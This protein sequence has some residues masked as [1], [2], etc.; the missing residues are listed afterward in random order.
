M[1]FEKTYI[2]GKKICLIHID[3]VRLQL[4]YIEYKNERVRVLYYK[5]KRLERDT[6]Q[7]AHCVKRN[8]LLKNILEIHH[9]FLQKHDSCDEIVFSSFWASAN[10]HFFEVNYEHHSWDI[11][12][13]HDLQKIFSHTQNI[14]QT[15]QLT[16]LG[17]KEE[18]ELIFSRIEEIKIDEKITKNLIWKKAKNIKLRMSYTSLSVDII[19]WYKEIARS[20]GLKIAAIIPSEYAYTVRSFPEKNICIFRLQSH[21][22]SVSVKIWGKIIGI[23]H[24]ELG[25]AHLYTKLKSQHQES[26][27]HIMSHIEDPKYQNEKDAFFEILQTSIEL[28]LED[29][30]WRNLCPQTIHISAPDLDQSSLESLRHKLMQGKYFTEGITESV[31]IHLV[32]LLEHISKIQIDTIANISLEIYSLLE[33]IRQHYI[34]SQEN[35]SKQLEN[36]YKELP[37]S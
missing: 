14:Y 37:L 29:I 18:H 26:L 11:I 5:K 16:D 19:E 9:D 8:N 1:N 24:I 12:W 13:N 2:E 32:R 23:W 30:L 4:C 25:S 34:F 36:F 33:E 10:S 7:A 6:F 17:S 20:L 15:K 35:I 31:D 21:S 27:L 3:T 22:S 28:A